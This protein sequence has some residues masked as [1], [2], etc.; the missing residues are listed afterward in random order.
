MT[1]NNEAMNMDWAPKGYMRSTALVVHP[2]DTRYAQPLTRDTPP[3]ALPDEDMEIHS[4]WFR[5][6]TTYRAWK[7]MSLWRHWLT[8]VGHRPSKQITEAFVY[9]AS[10]MDSTIQRSR[11]HQAAFQRLLNN[12]PSLSVNPEARASLIEL[13]Q[14]TKLK[15][16]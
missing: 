16:R 8:L 13:I 14:T 7:S 10:D 4:A 6:V 11:V 2:L 5:F 9:A 3:D 1:S 15:H 12:H